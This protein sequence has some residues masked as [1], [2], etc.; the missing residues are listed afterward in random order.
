[1]T[2]EESVKAT[3][4]LMEELRMQNEKALEDHKKQLEQHVC[5]FYFYLSYF[6]LII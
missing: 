6:I 5:F 3:D 4:A 2:S 1:M